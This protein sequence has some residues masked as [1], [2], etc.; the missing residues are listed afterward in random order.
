MH[1]STS[2][3]FQIVEEVA[4]HLRTLS[5]CWFVCGGWAI[6]LFVGRKTRDHQDIEIGI[7]RNDQQSL[8]KLSDWSWEY[9]Q[10]AQPRE[11]RGTPLELPIHELHGISQST[12]LSLEVLLNERDDANWIYRRNTRVTLPLTEAVRVTA[13]GIKYLAPEVVLLYKTKEPRA[14]DLQDRATAL[15]MMSAAAK[16]WLEAAE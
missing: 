12:N 7:F 5:A 14:K 3:D 6:D 9:I 11:W 8:L 10:H 16:A 2:S 15:P 13:S 4:H 1:E